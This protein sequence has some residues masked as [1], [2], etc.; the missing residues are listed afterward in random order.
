MR[1]ALLFE[2]AARGV[3][4]R[5]LCDEKLRGARQVAACSG[6]SHCFSLFQ[7]GIYGERPLI[8]GGNPG[9]WGA[10]ARKKTAKRVL[11]F[12]VSAI[13]ISDRLT[14]RTEPGAVSGPL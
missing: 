8:R 2:L 13:F 9:F 1:R 12:A 5:F 3:P 10:P 7:P 6:V 4:T 11:F 14:L